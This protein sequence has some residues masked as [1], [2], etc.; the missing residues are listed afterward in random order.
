MST[1]YRRIRTFGFFHTVH[2][3]NV[4]IDAEEDSTERYNGKIAI[5]SRHVRRLLQ[6]KVPS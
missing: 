2:G 4:L 6:D 3:V 1:L 5:L